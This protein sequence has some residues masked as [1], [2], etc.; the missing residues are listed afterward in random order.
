ML[1]I[2]L[3]RRFLK[4]ERDIVDTR[5]HSVGTIALISGLSTCAYRKNML[6]IIY[7]SSAIHIFLVLLLSHALSISTLLFLCLIRSISSCM[8][9]IMSIIFVC[10][11]IC[12]SYRITIFLQIKNFCGYT[13]EAWFDVVCL[14]Y[15]I[16]G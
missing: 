3:I 7:V 14:A 12:M 1:Y 4:E 15:H 2:Y 8:V 9:W 13:T 5:N 11:K 10:A 16:G 6:I